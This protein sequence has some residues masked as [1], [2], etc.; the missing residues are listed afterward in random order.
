MQEYLEALSVVSQKVLCEIIFIFQKSALM[1]AQN[2]LSQ[3]CKTL[4]YSR[5]YFR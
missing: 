2:F 4:S 3:T 5:R 1:K